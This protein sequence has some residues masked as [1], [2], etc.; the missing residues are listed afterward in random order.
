MTVPDRVGEGVV[1]RSRIITIDQHPRLTLTLPI[2]IL[3][4]WRRSELRISSPQSA[5]AICPH[6]C[7]RGERAAERSP[8]HL[9]QLMHRHHALV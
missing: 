3:A 5:A 8:L 1:I 6:G 9:H 4:K 2:P 7:A